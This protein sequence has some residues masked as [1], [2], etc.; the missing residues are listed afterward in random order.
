MRID[1]NELKGRRVR[2]RKGLLSRN[3]YDQLVDYLTNVLNVD[4]RDYIC[5]E[6]NFVCL[7]KVCLCFC[8]PGGVGFE[9]PK[10]IV[11]AGLWIGLLKG[12][13]IYLS[14]DL[15]EDIYRDVGFKAAIKVSEVGVKNF[16]YGRDVL[17]QSVIEKHPPLNNPLAVVDSTDDR[18]IGVVEPRRGFYRNVY[19]IGLFLRYFG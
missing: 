19:D 12:G 18:V 5:I 7:N 3:H 10:A 4:Y 11:Y 17:E 14:I 16:L 2:F 1:E 15:Y 9:D 8:N 13:R 6:P